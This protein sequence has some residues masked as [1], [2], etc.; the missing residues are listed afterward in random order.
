MKNIFL[1][2]LLVILY[3][4][5]SNKK[6]NYTDEIKLFQYKL[7]TEFA[8]EEESPL[9]EEDIKTFKSLEFFD[10]NEKYRIEAEFEL[11][12]NTPIFE[13]QTT[14]ERLPLYRI[15]GIA[16]FTLNGEKIELNIFQSQDLMLKYEYKNYLFLPFNDATN[17]KTTY[18][19]GRFIDLEIPENNGNTIIIDFNKAYNPLCAYNHKYSCPI[20]PKEN[21]IPIEIPVGVKAYEV[22]H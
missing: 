15:Y 20:P 16:R 14:T 4:S 6:T 21:N 13:M 11:T 8:N 1:P 19:G 3:T 17:N 22:Q 18:G 7:N 12:P 10:I 5:C 9:T 2:L